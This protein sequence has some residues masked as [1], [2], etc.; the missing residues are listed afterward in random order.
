MK[1]LTRRGIL[2]KDMGQIYR[3]EPDAKSARRAR[4]RPGQNRE[5]SGNRFLRLHYRQPFGGSTGSSGSLQPYS[6]YALNIR[7]QSEAAA[8]GSSSP[9]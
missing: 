8:R 4:S 7:T 6:D 9:R 2:E 5:S 1:L 3:A